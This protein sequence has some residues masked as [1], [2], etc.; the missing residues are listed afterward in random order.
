MGEFEPLAG[1]VGVELGHVQRALVEVLGAGGQ[2]TAHVLGVPQGLGDELVGVLVAC[3]VTRVDDDG[4]AGHGRR[5]PGALMIEA[6]QGRA[7]HRNRIR[8][9]GVDLDVPAKGVDDVTVIGR[10]CIACDRGVP[11]G[12]Q[13]I[14]AGGVPAVGRATALW[15]AV[16]VERADLG[17][18]AP[19]IVTRRTGDH[20]EVVLLTGKVGTPGGVAVAAV[21]VRAARHRAVRR[22]LGLDQVAAT[23]GTAEGHRCG[24]VD[25]AVVTRAADHAHVGSGRAALDFAD[26]HAVGVDLL[27]DLARNAVG[28]GGQAIGVQAKGLH[29]IFVIDRQQAA[30]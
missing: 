16:S 26:G 12:K 15:Q 1:A 28:A 24:R 20:V 25:A 4:L 6:A 11:T 30:V 13:V 14:G 9:K 19:G 5:G 18:A 8:R 7:L 23:H 17:G 29:D 10:S 21:V 22:I 3:I 2:A 27:L